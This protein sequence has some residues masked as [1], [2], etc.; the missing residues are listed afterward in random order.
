MVCWFSFVVWWLG[1]CF[2]LSCDFRFY[3]SWIGLRCV[4]FG[5]LFV[6]YLVWLWFGF[7]V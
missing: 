6:V 2:G 1:G 7:I 3:G 5:G 4:L